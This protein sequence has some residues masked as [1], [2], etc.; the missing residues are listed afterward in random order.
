MSNIGSMLPESFICD[1]KKGTPEK[2]KF[3]NYGQVQ[4]LKVLIA[5]EMGLN[6]GYALES[7]KLMQGEKVHPMIA[8]AVERESISIH[9]TM[10]DDIEKISKANQIGEA[11][12][13]RYGFSAK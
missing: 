4:A 10:C 6:P 11:I 8:R 2:K 7:A 9:N 1:E 12:M 13:S 5:A 3:L